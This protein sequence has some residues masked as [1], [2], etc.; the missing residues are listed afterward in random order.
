MKKFN[1]VILTILMAVSM[2][3]GITVTAS[4][5]DGVVWE[6]KAYPFYLLDKKKPNSKSNPFIIDTACKLANVLETF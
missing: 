5:R 1:S 2:F 3:F 6:G 4:A